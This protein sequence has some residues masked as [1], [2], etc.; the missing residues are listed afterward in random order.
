MS[1]QPTPTCRVVR[2]G[3]TYQVKQSLAYLAGTSA[4]TA[5]A[6]LLCLHLLT[7]PPG[8]RAKAHLHENHGT[9]SR[10]STS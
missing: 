9:T 3:E 6:Q 2:S 4:E 10:P 7:I 1:E 5:A 8:A